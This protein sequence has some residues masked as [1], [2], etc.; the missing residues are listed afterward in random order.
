MKTNLPEAINKAAEILSRAKSV[1]IF[2]GAG[3]SAESGIATFRDPGG[4]W[5]R[6][7]PEEVGTAEGIMSFLSEGGDKIREIIREVVESFGAA[8][9]NAGHLALAE[10]EKMGLIRS[11]I[12]QNIDNLHRE[13]GNTKVFEVHG[14]LFRFR[15]LNCEKKFFVDREDLLGRLRDIAQ[16]AGP[17]SLEGILERIPRCACGGVSRPDVVM[18]GESVQEL[19]ESIFEAHQ[20]DVMLVLGTSGAVYPAAMVPQQARKA[21]A[22]LIEVNPTEKV[23]A[24]ENDVY[25]REKAAIAMPLIVEELKK[26]KRK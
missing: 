1:V 17:L 8:R 16:G 5:D 23:F 25:I 6:F 11:V 12:T 2:T 10:L 15:C 18:F 13:A 9:P 22:I 24:A 4:L 26:K 3:M 20:S 7:D 21:G 19:D 14:N